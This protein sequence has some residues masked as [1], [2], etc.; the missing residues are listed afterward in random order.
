MKPDIRAALDRLVRA[1]G[2]YRAALL[3]MAVGLFLLLLPT[4][5]RGGE[6]QAGDEAGTADLFDLAGL[7]ERLAGALSQIEGAGEVRVILTLKSTG[8]QIPAQDVQRDGTRTSAQVVTVGGGAGG[9][10]VAVLQTLSP[11]FQGALVICPGGED[12]QVRLRLSSAVSALTG[13]GSDRITICKRA[14]S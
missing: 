7:E 9:R 2:R 3:V 13:L 11:Q 10:E 1:A 12:P 8:R 6:E 14:S 4:G 5:A